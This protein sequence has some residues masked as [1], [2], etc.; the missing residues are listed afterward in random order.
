MAINGEIQSPTGFT[1]LCCPIAAPFETLY[2]DCR[3]FEIL[4]YLQAESLFCISTVH[5]IHKCP[6]SK[7]GVH[8][9]CSSG[10][11]WHRD[12]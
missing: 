1:R 11:P 12:G 2:T 9:P 5:P 7:A 4:K 3:Y 10:L 8:N 6:W